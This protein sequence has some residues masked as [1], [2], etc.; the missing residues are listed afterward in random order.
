MFDCSP[1]TTTTEYQKV[2]SKNTLESK[3]DDIKHYQ[4]LI[5]SLIYAVMGTRPDL[6]YVI[7]KLSQYIMNPS[8]VHLGAAKRVLRFLKETWDQKL[9]DRYGQPLVLEG[10][11]DSDFAGCRDTRHSTSGYIFQLGQPTICW[12]SWKQRSVSTSTHEAEYMA[13]CMAAKQHIW[14]KN[15]LN[16]L[17]LKDIP[18][19]LS[20]Y[21]NGANDQAQ[22]PQ[23]GNRS[24]HID[25][26][27]HFTREL[28]ERGE[29]TILR[30]DS[31]DNPANICTKALK[32]DAFFRHYNSIMGKDWEGVLKQYFIRTSSVLLISL[33]PNL[34]HLLP[35]SECCYPYLFTL[36]SIL[37]YIW[38][39]QPNVSC[40]SY[41]LLADTRW[42]YM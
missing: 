30:I 41:V 17:G 26:Q 14:L 24:K 39:Y 21:N 23:V 36:M 18:S 27:Y 16:D 40:F 8:A 22:N 28:V 29:L 11:A 15:A 31:D 10:F 12:K 32:L 3:P 25:V 33:F 5:G 35:C 34:I 13:L 38:S 1:V 19:A 42:S 4:Q 6:S 2:I 20:C 37:Y 7:T 9:W